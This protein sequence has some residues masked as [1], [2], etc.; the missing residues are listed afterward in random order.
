MGM[1]ML[2]IYVYDTLYVCIVHNNACSLANKGLDT[3]SRRLIC[4]MKT[5]NKKFANRFF[6]YQTIQYVH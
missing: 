2:I 5:A 1:E 3:S 4:M 6:N